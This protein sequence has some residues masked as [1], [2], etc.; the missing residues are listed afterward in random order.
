MENKPAH[1]EKLPPSS[2]DAIVLCPFYKSGPAGEAAKKGSDQHTYAESLLND[3]EVADDCGLSAEDK[4]N[5]QW[6]VDLV[7][8]QASGK[9]DVEVKAELMDKNFN[10]ITFGTIDTA[11]SAEIWDYKSD[12]EERPHSYQ[13]AAYALMRIR[14]K[15]IPQVTAHICY[16]KLRKVVSVTF[17]EQE[18]WDMM[19]TVLAIYHNPERECRPCEYCGWCV[20]AVSCPALTRCTSLVAKN[21]KP[22]EGIVPWDPTE[23]TDPAVVSRMLIMARIVAPW[24]DAVEKHAKLMLK[25]GQK[26]PG[27]AV[28]ERAGSRQV[29][30]IMKA[31]QL[32]GLPEQ[33]FLKACSVKIG[34]LDDIYAEQKGMKKAAAKKELKE[35][36]AEVTEQRKPSVLLV[37]EKQT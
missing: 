4:D 3:L 19:E 24:A 26:I 32:V 17:T 29:K 13:M 33:E 16:G 14:Q 1:H 23:V 37:R 20:N 35:L 25:T 12:R 11:A 8:A 5:V 28:L 7:K 6:Y 34:A 2:L 31:F 10:E 27:W 21:Y 22:E 15:G 36:L 18:A 9:L 30:D